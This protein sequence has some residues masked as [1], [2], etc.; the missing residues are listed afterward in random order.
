MAKEKGMNRE[1]RVHGALLILNELVRISSMEGEV[2]PDFTVNTFSYLKTKHSSHCLFFLDSACVRRWRKSH[3]SNWSTISTAR[4]WWDS[5][6]SPATSHPSPAS[7]QCSRSSQTPSWAC[8][9]TVLLR[10]SSALEPHRHL[11]RTLWWRADTA[12]SWWRTDSIRW[13]GVGEGGQGWLQW[14]P[15]HTQDYFMC[16]SD[17]IHISMFSFLN[18]SLML[19]LHPRIN[20]TVL[21]STWLQALTAK[22]C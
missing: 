22:H 13:I 3:S 20:D 12:V 10:A 2:G 18:P 16:T 8:W 1:D 19:L 7:S 17:Y 14:L 4:R 5:E 6:P 11:L 9:A 21:F 15:T